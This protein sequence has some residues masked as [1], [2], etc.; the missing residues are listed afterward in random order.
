M[1][2]GQPKVQKRWSRKPDSA[3][4]SRPRRRPP[5]QAEL[6]RRGPYRQHHI[7]CDSGLRPFARG[8]STGTRGVGG[9]TLYALSGIPWSFGVLGDSASGNSSTDAP[10][11]RRVLETVLMHDGRLCG[12]V[13]CKWQARHGRRKPGIPPR[14]FRTPPRHKQTSCARH[15]INTMQ[16]LRLP[17]AGPPLALT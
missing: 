1:P 15:S 3:Q 17:A 9:G 2:V 4:E 14:R 16:Q 10:D 12:K 8:R 5:P 11:P 7:P 13:S 6:R